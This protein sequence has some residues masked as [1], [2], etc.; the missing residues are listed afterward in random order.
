LKLLIFFVFYRS[1]QQFIPAAKTKTT[2]GM[3]KEH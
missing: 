2:T 1:E 3:T